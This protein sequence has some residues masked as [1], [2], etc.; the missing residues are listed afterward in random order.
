MENIEIYRS[1]K[2]NIIILL[3]CIAFVCVCVYLTGQDKVARI[4]SW[5]GIAFFGACAVVLLYAFLRERLLHKPFLVITDSEVR[6]DGGFK[7]HSFRFSEV[8]R[9]T[10]ANVNDVLFIAAVLNE[11]AERRKMTDAS[12][13]GR[14]FHRAN[15]RLTGGM[16]NIPADDLTVKP[17]ELLDLL[18]QRLEAYRQAHPAD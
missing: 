15:I 2:K 3:V 6:M 11:R 16:E 13:A 9:F 5:I 12:P 10:W 8:E 18:N 7:L 4:V 17:N 14:F 1:R